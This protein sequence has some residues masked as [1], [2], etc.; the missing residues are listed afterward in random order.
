MFG[1]LLGSVIENDFTLDCLCIKWNIT[2]LVTQISNFLSELFTVFYII[3]ERL[4]MWEK[5]GVH[6]LQKIVVIV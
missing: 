6:F 4:C 1:L 2:L 5:L 3:I